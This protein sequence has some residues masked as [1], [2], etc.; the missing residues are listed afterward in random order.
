MTKEQISKYT[1]QF[2]RTF[3]SLIKVLYLS[4]ADTLKQSATLRSDGCYILGN[5]PS[6]KS[7]LEFESNIPEGFSTMAVNY[8]AGTD[9]YEKIKPEFYTIIS[10]EYW[11]GEE[12]D[13]WK[14][15]R[16][17]LFVHMV[18]QTTWPMTLFVPVYARRDEEWVSY[19]SENQNIKIE[20]INTTPIE[21]LQEISFLL[22]RYGLG[23]PR[24]HNVLVGSIFIAILKG[25]KEIRLLG[26]DHNWL[27]EMFIGE[28]NIVYIGQKHFYDEQFKDRT[29]LLRA[30]PK[31]MYVGGSK[32]PRKFHQILE[33]LYY[34]FQSYWE[35]REF[36]T[37]RKI[38][39]INFTKGSYIDAFERPENGS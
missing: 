24:P 28:D 9:S 38:K 8:F 6:L 39:I 27:E 7:F 15:E 35:L 31:P 12:D 13:S 22:Y 33:K 11:K 25:F 29:S 19:L 32:K 18:E 2:I 26:A 17:Q 21:G 10:P 36:A 34:T 23:I 16:K 37:R 3:A 1:E 5:G 14:N 30:D 20:Y 4:K